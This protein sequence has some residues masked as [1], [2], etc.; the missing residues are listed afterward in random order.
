MQRKRSV[1]V[2][3]TNLADSKL[4]MQNSKIIKYL[5][6]AP[7]AV[8]TT[9]PYTLDLIDVSHHTNPRGVRLEREYSQHL[10][11]EKCKSDLKVTE[12]TKRLAISNLRG[13]SPFSKQIKHNWFANES[14]QLS[15]PPRTEP[16]S[17]V[18]T[19]QMNSTQNSFK[20]RA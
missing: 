4:G 1:V 7:V 9:S 10:E 11:R 20:S 15:N 19:S 6:D 17:R 16:N 8:D 2:Q 13:F 3:P 14:P 18:A 5:K 12:N